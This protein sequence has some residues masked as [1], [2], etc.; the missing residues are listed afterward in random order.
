MTE[1]R[2]RLWPVAVVGLVL[3]AGWMLA[4][5]WLNAAQATAQLARA[6]TLWS[7]RSFMAAAFTLD[8]PL[9]PTPVQ[10]LGEL[11]RTMLG[12][13]PTDPRSVLYHVAVTGETAVTGFGLGTL[14]GMGLAIGIVHQRVLDAS[15]MPWII[16]SQTVPILA[17]APMVVVILGNM[18]LT[19][20]LPK[21]V[22][23]AYLSFFPVAI[24]MVKGLRSA[25]RL[26]LELMR[27]YSADA[28]QVFWRVRLPAS[29][30]Y[31]FASLKVAVAVSTVGAIVAELPTGG[32]AGLGARLLTGSYYGQTLQIWG[33]LA[34]AAALSLA[35][36]A[37]T[38]LA[39]RIMLRRRGLG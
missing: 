22:I 16:A 6:E 11:T 15:L 33:A 1:A 12:Y 26:V 25:D 28:R 19:G 36:V 30:P 39:E 4:A 21:A 14:V 38:G 37:T 17:I 18:G 34:M 29:L 35:L 9:L 2:A 13:A 24:G 23:C 32:T 20:L 27:T 7:L 5:L 31:L 3:L 10:L 8:R